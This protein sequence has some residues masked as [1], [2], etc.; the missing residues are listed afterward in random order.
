MTVFCY[1]IIMKTPSK[2]IIQFAAIHGITYVDENV[3]SAFPTHWHSAGEFM[4]IRKDGC[5]YRIGD[6]V[7][8]AKSGDILM[9][10]P[11][12]LHE[13]LHVPEEGSEFIQFSSTL[14]ESNTDLASASGFLYA[15]HHISAEEELELTAKIRQHFQEIGTFYRR[16]QYFSETRCKCSLYQ[17]LLLISEYVLQK[18]EN[19]MDRSHT[20]DPSRNYIRSACNYIS[21]HSAEDLSQAEVAAHTGISPYYF[22]RLFREYT[23][24]TFPAYLSEIRVQ[25]AMN[26]LADPSLSVTDCAFMAGFQSTTTFNKA[27]RELTGCT[28]REYRRMQQD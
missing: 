21:E 27:F 15:C 10:W 7:Y 19:K 5:R 3:P 20:F 18:Q 12:E 9:I 22:S 23:Q 28:P 16:N 6:T 2:E 17:I 8:T 4:V 26:L 13:V 14:I 1:H 24:M 11:C 25:N